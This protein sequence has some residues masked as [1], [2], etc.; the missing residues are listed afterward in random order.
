MPHG[1]FDEETVEALTALR[2]RALRDRREELLAEFPTAAWR[3]QGDQHLAFDGESLYR[4]WLRYIAAA[5][6][7]AAPRRMF[8]S[9][10]ASSG[11]VQGAKPLG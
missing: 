1:Y 5:E 4:N 7:R 8:A 6:A 11:R 9:R 3:R 10:G 2:E